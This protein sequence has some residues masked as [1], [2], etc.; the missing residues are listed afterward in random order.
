MRKLLQPA[1]CTAVT[2][3]VASDFEQRDMTAAR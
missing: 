2:E 1:L 3:E